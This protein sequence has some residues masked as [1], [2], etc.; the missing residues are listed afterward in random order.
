M[1]ITKTTEKIN[2]QPNLDEII[3]I[4]NIIVVEKNKSIIIY[5]QHAL[6]E[7]IIYEKLLNKE[8]VFQN[9]K[10]LIPQNIK[11]TPQELDT[12]TSNIDIIKE[13]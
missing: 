6:A 8:N 4:L 5:D 13:M 9:Q 12:L 1:D 11:L 2:T 10:L 7:R 3:S